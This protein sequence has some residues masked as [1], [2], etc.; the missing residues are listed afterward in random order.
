MRG[1]WLG[2]GLTAVAGVAA[3]FL[4]LSPTVATTAV[5]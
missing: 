4:Y 1:V 2:L 5:M 3:F